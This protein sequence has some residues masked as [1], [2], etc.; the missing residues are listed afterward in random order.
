L[1]LKKPADFVTECAGEYAN[2]ES[3]NEWTETEHC[4]K[5]FD[6]WLQ[7]KDEEGNEVKVTFRRILLNKCQEE[8]ERSNE[9]VD[10]DSPERTEGDEEKEGKEEKEEKEVK[11]LTPEQIEGECSREFLLGS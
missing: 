7:E 10:E 9:Q 2:P 8:F 3:W 6:F 1:T 4:A 11:K 5:A